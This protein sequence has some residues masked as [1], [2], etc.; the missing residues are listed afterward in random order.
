MFAGLDPVDVVGPLGA[1]AYFQFAGDD[2]F[3]GP[4]TRAAFTAA[5]PAARVSLY[6]RAEHD[7]GGADTRDDR[8]AWLAGRLA[9]TD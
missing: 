2:R 9:L 3:V 5:A 6:E 4:A 1:G 7:L 8:I